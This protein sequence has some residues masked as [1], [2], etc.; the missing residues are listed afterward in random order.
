MRTEWEYI[1]LKLSA[2]GFL[3]TKLDVRE[4]E[5]H[6]NELGVQGWELTTVFNTNNTGTTRDVVAVFKRPR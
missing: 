2:T 1:T 6:M 3:D 5:E 4:L